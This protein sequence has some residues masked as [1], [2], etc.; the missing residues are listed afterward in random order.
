MMVVVFIKMDKID[1]YAAERFVKLEDF[2][3]QDV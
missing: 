3:K 2:E 1:A